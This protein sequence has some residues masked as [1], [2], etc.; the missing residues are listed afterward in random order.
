MKIELKSKY[1]NDKLKIEFKQKY[2]VFNCFIDDTG[3]EFKI[4]KEELRKLC[5]EKK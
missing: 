1:H 3:N 2:V 4:E 5:K